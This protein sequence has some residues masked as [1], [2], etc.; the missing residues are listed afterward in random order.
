[1][2]AKEPLFRL[3]VCGGDGTLGWVLSQ[4]DKKIGTRKDLPWPIVGII[5][6]GTG[7]LHHLNAPCH[8][9]TKN[10]FYQEMICLVHVDGEQVIREYP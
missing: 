7:S 3:L 9:H 5:P 8:S 4:I 2:W 6:L 1:M 10:I